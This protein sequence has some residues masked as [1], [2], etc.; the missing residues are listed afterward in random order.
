MA[1]PPF[2]TSSASYL[3][4]RGQTPTTAATLSA[5]AL[6]GILRG[7][8]DHD[9]GCVSARRRQHNK[10][11]FR[12]LFPKSP[13]GIKQPSCWSRDTAAQRRAWNED[14]RA[15]GERSIVPPLGRY[16]VITD[17]ALKL[18][19]SMSSADNKST[20]VTISHGGG[21]AGETQPSDCRQTVQRPTRLQTQ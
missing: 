15:F 18:S 2:G 5:A 3:F 6:S 21:Q 20:R 19:A 1:R 13:N 7:R 9:A 14:L 8:Q 10:S 16:N 4:V 11:E 17:L 12:L